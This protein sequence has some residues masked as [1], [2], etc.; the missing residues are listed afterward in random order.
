M[1]GKNYIQD[2][3]AKRTESYFIIQVANFSQIFVVL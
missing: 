2:G 3:F 1:E